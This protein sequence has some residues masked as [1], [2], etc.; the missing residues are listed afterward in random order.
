MKR[1]FSVLLALVLFLSL[2]LV[3]AAPAVATQPQ[4]IEG[5][6]TLTSFTLISER[7]AG[8]NTI[9][10]FNETYEFYGSFEGT[11]LATGTV[12]IHRDGTVNARLTGTFT[13]TFNGGAI[14]TAD[15]YLV[16]RGLHPDYTGTYTLVGR[17]GGLVGLHGVMTIV[18]V[19]FVGGTY[20]GTVHFDP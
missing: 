5:T 7:S 17:T 6:Y 3:M 15:W 9:L 11:E 20:S 1:I 18:G 19:A 10:T 2:S 8:G 4:T 12:V 13:G 16:A 14:G